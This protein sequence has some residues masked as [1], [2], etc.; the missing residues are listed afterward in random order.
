MPRY[1]CICAHRDLD[2]TWS[3]WFDGLTIAHE[4]NGDTTLH[5]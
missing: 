1:Y 2:P 3:A 5:G 4:A